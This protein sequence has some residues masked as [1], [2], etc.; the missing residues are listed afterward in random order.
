VVQFGG[1]NADH[2]FKSF[3]NER[4]KNPPRERAL[5][6]RVEYLPNN[7]TRLFCGGDMEA[8]C[9]IRRAAHNGQGD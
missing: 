7:A 9:I 6:I 1:M 2:I 4:G 5:D 3:L 8:S